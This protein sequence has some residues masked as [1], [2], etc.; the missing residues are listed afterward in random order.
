VAFSVYADGVPVWSS[1]TLR[2]GAAAVPVHVDLTG[3]RTVR[4][5]V[6]SRGPLGGVA[7]ADW[8]ASAFT[9]GATE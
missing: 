9:C 3:H 1:G 8:A 6:A 2:G 7:L 4:L 5:V